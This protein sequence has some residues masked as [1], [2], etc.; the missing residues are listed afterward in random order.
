MDLCESKMQFEVIEHS[1]FQG[2]K[3]RLCQL[4]PPQSLHII[5]DFQV[6]VCFQVIEVLLNGDMQFLYTLLGHSAKFAHDTF[7]CLYCK[8][9]FKNGEEGLLRNIHEFDEL[10][11]MYHTNLDTEASY[12]II[13]PPLCRIPL[14][15]VVPF[16]L[17]VSLGEFIKTI[18]SFKDA[19]RKIDLK[20]KDPFSRNTDAV[21]FLSTKL[22][23][24]LNNFTFEST[25]HF[26]FFGLRYVGFCEKIFFQ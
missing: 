20:I 3:I 5:C 7:R 19:C 26:F 11:K 6:L 18:N 14:E 1:K 4:S 25:A 2:S 13:N 10:S 21:E 24:K 22:V 17:H 8:F 23:L 16:F 12:N 9:N 15:R